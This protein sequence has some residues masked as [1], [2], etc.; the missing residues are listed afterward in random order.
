MRASIYATRAAP[1]TNPK[2][3][4][5]TNSRNFFNIFGSGM[6]KFGGLK[7]NV[8]S[9]NSSKN[10]E[11]TMSAKTRVVAGMMVIAR[12]PMR[13]SNCSIWDG[14]WNC[15]AMRCKAP[16]MVATMGRTMRYNVPESAVRTDGA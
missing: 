1:T 6:E 8:F 14:K 4:V 11:K 16:K 2:T 13:H 3:P 7:P 5:S 9:R 12:E 10:K 15:Q